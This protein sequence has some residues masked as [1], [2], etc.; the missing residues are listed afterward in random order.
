[1]NRSKSI[2]QGRRI[3]TIRYDKGKRH[4]WNNQKRDY[5]FYESEE[6]YDR[7]Y[8]YNNYSLEPQKRRHSTI[9]AY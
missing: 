1:M 7:D 3:D 2:K 8:L 4:F 5:G 6:I 9:G